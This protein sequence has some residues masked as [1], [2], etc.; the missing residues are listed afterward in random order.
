M[1]GRT[2]RQAL[3][4]APSAGQVGPSVVTTRCKV[5]QNEALLGFVNDGLNRGLSARGM[6]ASL[7]AIGGKLDPDIINRHRSNH[8]TPP[9]DPN[10]VKPTQRDL[11]IM[12]RDKVAE[13]IQDKEPDV[14]LAL[15]KEFGP[16]I[17]AGLK[18]QASIDKREATNRKLGIAEGALG[19]QMFL[20]GL[21]RKPELP[22]PSV[23]EGEA[24]VVSPE[25]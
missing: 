11:N 24:V 12:V 1:G 4:G 9:R 17:N 5:C 7:E 15:G 20:A 2:V 6:A 25:D 18:A 10:A 13:A 14:L 3:Q 21:G 16:F 23:I 22:D 8:W 19:F